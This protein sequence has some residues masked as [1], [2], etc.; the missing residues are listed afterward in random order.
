LLEVGQPM[1][2]F[3]LH[4]LSGD[5]HV[6]WA[7][8]EETLT[9]LNASVVKLESD[10]LV[11]ADDQGP[12]ALAGIMGG[13]ATAVSDATQDIFLESAFF[14][15]DSIVGRARRLG[16]S[17]DSSFRFERGVD[18]E[19]CQ[20]ALERATQLILEICGGQA[21]PIS[22]EEGT[23]SARPKIK[24]RIKKLNSILG[25]TLSEGAVSQLLRQLAF[26]FSLENG[27]FLVTAPSYRF[28][29][30]R[31]EDLIEEV[32]RLHGYDNIPAIAP[33]S[34][35]TMLPLS[36]D[37]L[38]ISSV[39]ELLV[40]QGYQEVVTYSFV[41]EQWERDL[42]GNAALIKLKNPIASNMSVMRS[43]L[44]GGLLDTLEYNLNRQQTR[45]RLFE[46]G[47]VYQTDSNQFKEM[48]RISGLLYG[49]SVPEQWASQSR[50]VDF[51]DIKAHVDSL[52]GGLARYEV[53]EHPS[54]HPG[55]T[56]KVIVE[57]KTIGVVGK[58]HPKWQQHYQFNKAVFLFELDLSSILQR[59]RIAYEEISKFPPIRRDIA[60]LV[61]DAVKAGDIVQT[62]KKAKLAYVE[63]I[64]LFD[65]YRGKGIPEGQ[66]SLAF[67]V[68]IQDKQK[69]LQDSDADQV[70][71]SLLEIIRVSHGATLR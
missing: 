8:P 52:T 26:D 69:S 2:A 23:I 1:H 29:I 5:I 37:S 44:W 15:P 50:E 40:M 7:M 13:E 3:D 41:D 68:M 18:F 49:E 21:G 60:V 32:A 25:I 64:E 34:N 61:D 48:T 59:K 35:Q 70:V 33:I 9:L 43:S 19:L 4:K 67:M 14:L 39:K 12:V 20:K 16:L 38:S 30:N 24:L 65:V 62:M 56:A 27:E 63:D 42:L 31:E 51:Y 10:M 46:V 66:K 58:L 71:T 28:D 11:I 55:Q 17:T 54:L 45:A 22:F 6:R 36:E 53:S 47:A 57:G